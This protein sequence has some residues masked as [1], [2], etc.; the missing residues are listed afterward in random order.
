MIE[1]CSAVSV[2]HIV[3]LPRSGVAIMGGKAITAL[4]LVSHSAN[5]AD[6]RGTRSSLRHMQ[7]LYF[8]IPT[9]PH[10]TWT[11]HSCCNHVFYTVIK[12]KPNQHVCPRQQDIFVLVKKEYETIYESH[13][14]HDK[15]LL[16]STKVGLSTTYPYKNKHVFS[17]L[18][19]LCCTCARLILQGK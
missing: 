19:T 17:S 7:V 1:S 3:T 12:Q 14:K 13:V 5:C 10:P 8:P 4:L 2:R 18:S 16:T 9:Q 6:M 15:N 11:N